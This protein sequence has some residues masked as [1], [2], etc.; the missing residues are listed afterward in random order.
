M[1]ENLKIGYVPYSDDLSH[2]DDRRRFPF[3]AS[4]FGIQYEIADANRSYELI[5]LPAPANLTR[6]LE[7]K[8]RNPGTRFI[9]EMVD[10]LIYQKD[11]FNLLFKGIGRYLT[12]K[13]D[14]LCRVHR[15]LLINWIKIADFVIC[16]NP[17]VKHEIQQWNKNVVLSLDYLEHEYHHL[18]KD[19]AIQGKM[20][21]FWEGQ[22]VVLPQLLAYK[23]VFKAVNSFCELHVVTSDSYPRYGQF[24]N[25]KTESLLNEL[26]IETHFHKWNLANNPEL[27]SKFDCGIIPISKKD[28]YAWHKPANKL[29]SFWFSGIPTLASDTPAYLNVAAKTNS[30][31]I[32]SSDIEWVDKIRQMNEFSSKE[33]ENISRSQIHA[34]RQFYSNDIHDQ[35]WLGL[36]EKISELFAEKNESARNLSL[37]VAV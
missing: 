3:F 18:K 13:E 32:C 27:F 35:F 17:L 5:I 12:R 29:L 34:A 4:R 30:D 8:K 21:L 25:R 37:R 22:G 16:S 7:Y 28:K 6:W 9:F 33:R 19:Y 23:D 36:F 10:S 31:F 14:H 2:P 20:K 15:E 24:L 26:P 11:W 1:P